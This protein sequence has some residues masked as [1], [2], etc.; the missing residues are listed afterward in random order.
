MSDETQFNEQSEI[1]PPK[2]GFIS[3]DVCSSCEIGVRNLISFNKDAKEK[4]ETL[5]IYCADLGEY[6]SH[7]GFW[8]YDTTK[9]WSRCYRDLR[10]IKD[11]INQGKA[12]EDVKIFYNEVFHK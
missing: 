6:K 9:Y 12:I 10:T 5:E 2:T 7:H 3:D 1:I 11:F 8:W 4:L